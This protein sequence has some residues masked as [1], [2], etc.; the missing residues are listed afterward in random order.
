MSTEEADN[1]WTRMAE[2]SRARGR[3]FQ[4]EARFAGD[5]GG[6]TPLRIVLESDEPVVV[7]SDELDALHAQLDPDTIAA[8]YPEARD[9][10]RWREAFDAALGSRRLTLNTACRVVL[11]PIYYPQRRTHAYNA[12]HELR[13]RASEIAPWVPGVPAEAER[14]YSL[15][16]LYELAEHGGAAGAVARP[17][18]NRIALKAL[19]AILGVTGGFEVCVKGITVRVEATAGASPGW[20]KVAS[21]LDE[22]DD[23]PW[24]SPL[25]VACQW[26]SG[27][28]TL[29]VSA[30]TWGTHRLYTGVVALA[31]R[32]ERQALLWITAPARIWSA[33]DE[34]VVDIR[35]DL[36]LKRRGAAGKEANAAAQKIVELVRASNVP[37]STPKQAEAFKLHVP[38]GRVLP[39]PEE[40]LRRL[41]V[42]ALTKQPFLARANGLE[43]GV[44]DP[45][46]AVGEIELG[47][48]SKQAVL[49]PLPGGVR[50]DKNTFD[51]LV[52]WLSGGPRSDADLNHYVLEQFDVDDAAL[53]AGCRRLLLTLGVAA[54][55][56]AGLVLTDSGR[57]YL[58]DP[59]AKR[60]FGLLNEHFV[61]IVETLMAVRS[62]GGRNAD[63]VAALRRLPGKAGDELEIS[64][65]RNWML[66]LGLTER[67]ERGE[68]LTARG[69]EVLQEHAG[70][71]LVFEGDVDDDDVTPDSSGDTEAAAPPGWRSDRLDL[72]ASSVA[73]HLGSLNLPTSLLEQAC[74]ALSSGKHL[75]LVGPPGTGKTELAIVLSKA[76]QAEGYCAGLF[77][78]T[79]SADWTTYET[80]GGYAL[81]KDG[82]LA[83]R[84]G[85]F[86]R[87]LEQ[88]QW[89]L[90]DELNRA[91]IDKAF[92]ELMT[93]LSGK[94]SDTPF[95]GPGNRPIGIGP[96]P[97]RSHF[98]PKTF[99]VIATMN[100]WDKTSLFRL[101][102]AVQRRFA[103][104]H[105][106]QPDAA[107]Y[108]RLLE[109]EATRSWLEPALPAPVTARLVELFAPNRLLAIRPVG[110]AIP[111]D[112]IR[113]MRRRRAEHVGMAEAIAMYLLPQLEGIEPRQADELWG[114]LAA[115]VASHAEAEP[116]LRARFL[117]M[118]PL[119][120]QAR[121]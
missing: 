75:L 37:L 79:A 61:G 5:A 56:S 57:G 12:H 121:L 27:R 14:E 43:L 94:G 76:A 109:H 18:S 102:Y 117:E 95:I 50:S 88:W 83:F 74:A 82:R 113:Y 96:E 69:L 19:R 52:A 32:D 73:A 81:E 46:D 90:I 25:S 72:R 116:Y 111:L 33:S 16:D 45:D 30:E 64:A 99:R 39:S 92:G 2:L 77:T 112:M 36:S 70:S 58:S 7:L 107:T 118:F 84:S 63:I 104:I 101:S 40:A 24:P 41:V 22:R 55:T 98:M 15:R 97:T 26:P 86:L 47:G 103:I 110:P 67:T 9:G 28:T 100:L 85:V 48:V 114:L 65:R 51:E 66:A 34:Q 93:V 38:S 42:V 8:R 108:S 68:S 31:I 60:L 23:G 20:P 62:E 120:E 80:I 11:G 35:A 119:A 71:G 21:E 87:A 3:P 44:F 17:D 29:S 54:A 6:A 1:F 106:G 53:V 89:L 4:V 49:P 115:A 78:S 59:T 13:V 105:V 10:Q 91:D